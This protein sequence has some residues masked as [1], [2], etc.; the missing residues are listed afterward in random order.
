[1]CVDPKTTSPLRSAFFQNSF[2]HVVGVQVVAL[3]SLYRL[4][5]RHFEKVR[6]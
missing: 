6:K 2:I 4:L 1:L 3:P 5:E